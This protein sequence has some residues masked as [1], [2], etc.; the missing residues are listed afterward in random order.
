MPHIEI[1]H[2]PH[3]LSE[4]NKQ[5]LIEELCK[6][7]SNHFT[8]SKETISLALI[9]VELDMWMDSV[10]KQKMLTRKEAIILWPGYKIE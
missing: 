9:P 7:I 10:V 6:V 8:T 4:Q 1:S 5:S 3:N 2:Y